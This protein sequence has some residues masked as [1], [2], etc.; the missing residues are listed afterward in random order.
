MTDDRNEAYRAAIAS[1]SLGETNL[2]FEESSARSV[3]WLA[4]LQF[5]Y[6]FAM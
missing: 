1:K 4:G 5:S 6:G 3:R 2:R